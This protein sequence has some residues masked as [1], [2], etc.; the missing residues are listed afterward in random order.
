MSGAYTL[1]W[2]S[3]F[4]QPETVLAAGLITCVMFISLT[5]YVWLTPKDFQKWLAL[6]SAFLGA[7]LGFGLVFA[8]MSTRPFHALICLLLVGLYSLYLVLDTEAVLGRTGRGAMMY[9][10]YILGTLC[11]YKVRTRQ[12]LVLIMVFLMSL[13]GGAKSD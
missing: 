4:F 3:A 10:D 8:F 1:S 7:L 2:L 12:D 5:L 13:F 11:I 6:P 9:D